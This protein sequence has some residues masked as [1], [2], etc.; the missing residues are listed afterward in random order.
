MT[1]DGAP[2]Y[3]EG[4]RRLQDK[5]D[6]RRI[7]DRLEQV[8]LHDRFTPGDIDFIENASMFFLATADGDGWPDVSYKGGLPG[9]VQVTD[10][11]ELAFPA[12]DGNGM[13][14]SFGNLLVHPKCG[15]LFIDFEEQDR[16][17]VQGTA[18][19]SDDDPLLERFPGALFVIRVKAERIFP[20]CPRYIHR[21]RLE[22]YSAFAPRSEYEP[23]V[24]DWKKMSV[25]SDALPREGPMAVSEEDLQ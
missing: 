13:F 23:P 16:M 10:Y 8:T 3:H 17:R 6:S 25:F 19:I 1:D 2:L 9:F 24:P 15:L 20:N 12:Y 11:D 18:S 5:F 4:N 21:M 22:E 7:A 14:K